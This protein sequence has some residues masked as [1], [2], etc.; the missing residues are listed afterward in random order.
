ML[1][2]DS[3][4]LEVLLLV[5]CDHS[6]KTRDLVSS[7]L[8]VEEE[9]FR[10][11]EFGGDL[12]PLIVTYRSFIRTVMTEDI[13]I[14]GDVAVKTLQLKIQS[15]EVLK[16]NPESRDLL[17]DIVSGSSTITERQLDGYLSNLRNVMIMRDAEDRIRKLFGKV[18]QIS[19]IKDP[20]LKNLEIEQLVAASNTLAETLSKKVNEAEEKNS[21]HF[22]SLSDT[23][24]IL[25]ALT[26]YEERN[27]LGGVNCG[28]QGL[29][30]ALGDRG[31]M[32]LGEIWAFAARSH[33]FKSGILTL[34]AL[35]AVIYNTYVV[36]PGKKALVWFISLEDEPSKILVKILRLVVARKEGR[37]CTPED[38]KPEN[39]VEYL[40]EY[41]AQFNVELMIDKFAPTDFSYGV[42]VR[43][44]NSFVEAG[45]H[46]VVV[47]LDYMS[48]ATGD[49][50][51]EMGIRGRD[52][53]SDRIVVEQN[54]IRFRHHA[55]D[56]GYLLPTGHQLSRKA[57][58]M[59][60]EPGRHHVV[61][62][63]HPGLM[64]N[65]SDVMRQV[66]G[67]IFTNIESNL[68]GHKF[69]TFLLY[70]N[71]GNEDTVE[72]HK[73]FAY[74]FCKMGIMDD[75][76]GPAQFVTDINAWSPPDIHPDLATRA[77]EDN[78]LF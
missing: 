41:F 47:P 38:L 13:T 31:A 8:E 39:A 60:G 11:R 9:A 26:R 27:V 71:R 73:F 62:R 22:I 29:N 25:K 30:R 69:L 68:D 66:D 75:L 56:N 20:N 50:S 63:F 74:P 5:L 6:T 37:V 10:K 65:T 7:F 12:D 45:Y 3:L 32:G 58:D 52:S 1:V 2:D 33:H 34:I 77:E 78:S 23:D 43:K 18:R 72:S 21:E 51:G 64:A 61:K 42:Y 14:N 4:Y 46:P 70:K 40:K 67:L 19:E 28:L 24:S 49:P 59:A 35:W 48:A 44:F 55:M 76:E 15:N 36:P 54:Y 16:D 53:S 17:I 57:D